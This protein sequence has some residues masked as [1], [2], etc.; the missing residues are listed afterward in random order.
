M[1]T[2][3]D[4]R[5]LSSASTAVNRKARLE[6]GA[7]D[8]LWIAPSVADAIATAAIT[9]ADRINGIRYASPDVRKLGIAPI[10]QKPRPRPEASIDRNGK[11]APPIS[12]EPKNAKPAVAE[13]AR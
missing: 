5:P 12:E 13:Q 1:E 6:T 2:L 11:V 10:S 4:S 9:R 7:I 3:G 8:P